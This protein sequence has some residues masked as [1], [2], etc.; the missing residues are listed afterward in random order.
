MYV[1]ARKNIGVEEEVMQS[2]WK[3]QEKIGD[4]VRPK[5]GEW[6]DIIK[7]NSSFFV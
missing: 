5:W 1:M 3:K 4:K 6:N 2:K 7:K